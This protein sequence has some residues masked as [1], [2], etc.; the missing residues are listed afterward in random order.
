MGHCGHCLQEG[1]LA[2]RHPED[3]NRARKLGIG[4]ELNGP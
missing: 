2:G 3:A 4:S 1:A